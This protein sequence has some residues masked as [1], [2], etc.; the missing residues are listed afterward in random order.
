M[1]G[2]VRV[3]VV[4]VVGVVKVQ[5]V[6]VV[7]VVAATV[8]KMPAVRFVVMGVWPIRFLEV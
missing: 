5:V 8:E 7:R 3:Q 1:V 6:G 2:V 4:G